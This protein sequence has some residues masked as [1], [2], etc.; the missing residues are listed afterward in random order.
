MYAILLM[1]LAAVGGGFVITEHASGGFVI[2][3]F[4]VVS[5]V[6]TKP[7]ATKPRRQIVMI[8]GPYCAPCVMFKAGPLVKL[9]KAGWKVGENGHINLMESSDPRCK[10][11]DVGATPCFILFDGDNEVTRVEHYIDQW[12]IGRLYNQKAKLAPT[13]VLTK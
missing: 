2:T 11:W 10:S 1:L 9:K 12:E 5:H 3:D 7:A 8:S 13:A 6:A 4:A